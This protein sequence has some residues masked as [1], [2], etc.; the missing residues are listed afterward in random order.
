MKETLEQLTLSQFVDLVCGDTD[1]LLGKHEI[2]HSDKLAVATRNIV[3]E[4]R[5]IAD[6]GGT[7]SY[8]KHVEDWIKAKMNVIIFTMCNNLV[9][10]KQYGRAREVLV[11]YGL[12]ASGWPDSR[13]DGTIQAKLA[14]SQRELE[15]L[16]AEN[17]KAIAE[18]DKIRSQFDTQT[19]SLMA[20][21][22]FQ[23]DPA[24]IKATVYAN[25][26]ARHNREIKVQMAAM[27]KKYS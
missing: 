12:S 15:E 7:T 5:A 19:A 6:P 11:E 26:V 14:Q 1:V 25:L 17:E 3:L 9:L 24:T 21:F 10:L 8:F 2:G 23:I 16:E 13:V 4:Y 22:K 27:K 20:H 18:C